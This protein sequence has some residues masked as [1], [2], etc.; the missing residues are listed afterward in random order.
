MDWENVRWQQLLRQR[1]AKVQL[2]DSFF[3]LYYSKK[4]KDCDGAESVGGTHISYHSLQHSD[5]IPID[6]IAQ[7]ITQNIYCVILTDK[8]NHCMTYVKPRSLYKADAWFVGL[9][10]HL[11]SEPVG[12]LRLLGGRFSQFFHLRKGLCYLERKSQRELLLA[13]SFTSVAVVGLCLNPQKYYPFSDPLVGLVF[14]ERLSSP[15]PT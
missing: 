2:S 10:S 9:I 11:C 14:S 13:F 4:Y 12:L 6:W 3:T 1:L 5:W 15:R 7:W 8:W